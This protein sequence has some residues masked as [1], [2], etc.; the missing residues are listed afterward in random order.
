[1]SGDWAVYFYPFQKNVTIPGVLGDLIHYHPLHSPM[2]Q[3]IVQYLWKE[4]NS[5]ESI[6]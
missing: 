1:M 3:S 4:G 6:P 5:V 2:T